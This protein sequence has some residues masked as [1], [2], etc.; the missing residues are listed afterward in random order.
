RLKHGILLQGGVS[1]GQ[2]VTDICNVLATSPNATAVGQFGAAPPGN[3]PV[4]GPY[5]HQV[6]NWMGQ[7]QLKMLGTYT[8]PKADVTVAATFQSVPGPQ[9]AA[10]YI[11][12]NSQVQPT[13]GRALSGGAANVTVNLIAP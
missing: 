6:T 4:G 8:V 9:V 10:N 12:P 3:T 13:L 11:V 2:T 7:T 5:C 1:T